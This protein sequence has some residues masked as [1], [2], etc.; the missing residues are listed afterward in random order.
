MHRR[1]RR[2]GVQ[3]S[4]WKDHTSSWS[5]GHPQCYERRRPGAQRCRRNVELSRWRFHPVHRHHVRP[6]NSAQLLH[7]LLRRWVEHRSAGRPCHGCHR[8]RYGRH[9]G[10][11][12]VDERLLQYSHRRHRCSGFSS[13]RRRGLDETTLRSDQCRTAIRLHFYTPYDGIRGNQRAFGPH[14]GST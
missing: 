4:V 8:N 12:P 2:D 1:R 5:N 7:G 11:I 6:G 9:R 13:H 10:G 3:P 14:K